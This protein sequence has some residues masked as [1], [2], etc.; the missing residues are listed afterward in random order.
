M[1][2]PVQRTRILLLVALGLALVWEGDRRTVPPL[3]SSL[4]VSLRLEKRL[5]LRDLRPPLSLPVGPPRF[6]LDRADHALHTGPSE[7]LLVQIRTM[8][9]G[10]PLLWH[11]VVLDT[12]TWQRRACWPDT[13]FW[14]EGY[15][16]EHN[17]LVVYQPDELQVRNVRTGRRIGKIPLPPAEPHTDGIHGIVVNPSAT[18]CYVTRRLP[19][20]VWARWPQWEYVL[21]HSPGRPLRLPGMLVRDASRGEGRYLSVS[22]GGWGGG[23]VELLEPATGRRRNNPAVNHAWSGVFLGEHGFLGVERERWLTRFRVPDL[24]REEIR[25]L[26][27]GCEIRTP[28]VAARDGRL[29]GVVVRQEERT[30]LQLWRTRPLEKVAE[31]LLP[32]WPNYWTM[33]PDA[34][35][36]VTGTWTGEVSVFRIQWSDSGEPSR[37]K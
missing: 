30:W 2:R 37:K 22:A 3:P 5:T 10:N 17:Q 7:C 6:R 12:R 26:P 13:R 29:A 36:I 19:G 33:A 8:M 11:T 20:D 15:A 25:L 32:V 23:G 27:T 1:R 34:S 21:P 31:T 4:R 14:P 9:I 24:M 18:R 35:H 28:L 16:A